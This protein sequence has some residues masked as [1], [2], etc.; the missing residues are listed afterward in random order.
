M[1]RRAISRN[2]WQRRAAQQAA[3]ER[4]LSRYIRLVCGHVTTPDIDLAYSV[5]RTKA[6]RGKFYCENCDDWI[7]QKPFAEPVEDSDIPLF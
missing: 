6:H 7:A 4:S 3:I 5:W 2:T 1:P